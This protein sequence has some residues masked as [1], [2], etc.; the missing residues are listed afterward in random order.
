MM[1]RS[2]CARALVVSPLN[3]SEAFGPVA[4]TRLKA[5]VEGYMLNNGKRCKASVH[6]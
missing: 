5:A 2:G 3:A 4:R 1:A 6:R